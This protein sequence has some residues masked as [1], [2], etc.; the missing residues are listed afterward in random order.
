V[1]VYLATHPPDSDKFQ[2]FVGD[3]F[4]SVRLRFLVT[5]IFNFVAGPGSDISLTPPSKLGIGIL[6]LFLKDVQSQLY[7]LSCAHVLDGKVGQQ[8]VSGTSR[9]GMLSQ[10]VK[11]STAP[12]V[13]PTNPRPQAPNQVDCALAELNEGNWN[14]Q[15]LGGGVI[16]GF[17][18]AKA[19]DSVNMFNNHRQVRGTVI[20]D[21][22]DLGIPYRNGT[23]YFE[24]LIAVAMNSNDSPIQG[25]DSGTLV[26]S[27]EGH[28]AGLVMA[29]S[30]DAVTLDNPPADLGQI[31]IVCDMN[32]IIAQLGA[33][34]NE[35]SLPLGPLTLL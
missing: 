9:I 21:S 6:G 4:P 12:L 19:S 24:N 25:G 30:Q 35:L 11:I 7:A 5:G 34:L 16:A 10:K 22:A 29:V 13:N 32:T 3:K 20:S 17:T 33:L 15:L 18:V 28:A 31:A 1:D 2:H 14:N 23:A 27:E 8:V 26:T